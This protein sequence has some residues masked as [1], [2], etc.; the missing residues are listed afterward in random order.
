MFDK[1]IRNGR[2]VDGTGRPAFIAD[3][4]IA[5]GKIAAVGRDL[6]RAREDIDADGRIVAPGW[7][8]IHSHYDGQAT[9]DPLLSPSGQHGVTTTV[10]GNCGVGFAPARPEDREALITLMEGVE[11][12]PGSAL[13]EGLPWTWQGFPEYLDR[14][15]EMPRVMDIAA[16]IPHSA[17]RAYVMG[18]EASIRGIATPAEMAEMEAIVRDGMAAGAIGFSTSRTK[19]HLGADG[20]P[21]PGSFVEME[22][23]LGLGHAVGAGGGGMLQLVC[24]WSRDDPAREFAWIRRLS[25]ETRQPLS[26]TLVQF[27][28]TPDHPRRLL[29]LLA[30]ARAEGLPIHA[31]VGSRPVGMLINLESKIHPF[32]DH[33]SYAAI[34]QL[35]LAAKLQRMRDPAFRTQL[36]AEESISQ[37]RY[38]RPKMQAWGNMFPLGDP[39]Q[40]EPG[41]ERS[42]AAQAARAGRTPQELVYDLMIS[43]E[44]LEWLY[45]PMINYSEGSLEPQ[46][47]MMRDPGGVISLADGGAHCG[48]ICDAS[49]PTFQ[50]THWVKARERGARLG[51][52]EAVHFQTG[53]TAA[54]WG[55]T[56]RG[57]I[58][59]GKRADLNIIDFDRLRLLPPR[60]AADL[61]A[62]GRRLL[63]DAEGYDATFVAGRMTWQ[64]GEPTGERPGRL[65]RKV[66]PLVA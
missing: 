22:E 6:G 5:D 7:V 55:F 27:D 26:F 32:S 48:L 35:P 36:L 37:N 64:N 62:G 9:W 3:V 29:S 54:M 65:V 28:E 42:I 61:P 50:L 33:P 57:V 11:D 44:G 52:E 1:V 4:A 58:A 43:G 12:I 63:Q 40:Y 8:D 59:P 66:E 56:D 47:E 19:L 2:V 18:P 31:G 34:A 30:E 16:L 46:L 38:W 23:L 45:F 53:R 60:W 17:V 10:M 14:L 20:K 25:R 49:A 51:L 21:V 39:P 15:D 41:P 24:D 13:S